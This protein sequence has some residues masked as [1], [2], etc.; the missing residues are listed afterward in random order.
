MAN[1][2]N[3]HGFV[4]VGSLDGRPGYF[5]NYNHVAS[6]IV[7]IGFNDLVERAA[8]GTD[9]VQASAGGPFLGISHANGAVSTLYTVPVEIVTPALIVEGQTDGSLVTADTGLNANVIV[10]A[11][12][13]TTGVSNMEINSASEDTTSTLDL[14]LLTLAPYVGNASGT[15]SR[16]FCIVNDAAIGDLKAGV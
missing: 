1:S 9:V 16:W 6:D 10:A 4:S 2:D 13:A 3:P 11:R 5:R 7:A 14:R 12:N 8:A 15:N